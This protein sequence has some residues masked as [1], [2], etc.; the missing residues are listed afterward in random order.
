ML[1]GGE[2]GGLRHRAGAV[3]GSKRSGLDAVGGLGHAGANGAHRGVARQGAVRQRAAGR[4]IALLAD[5]QPVLD[6]SAQ[7]G[8]GHAGLAGHRVHRLN[9][10]A[11]RRLGHCSRVQGGSKSAAVSQAAATLPLPNPTSLSATGQLSRLT[12]EGGGSGR[13]GT[14]AVGTGGGDDQGVGAGGDSIQGV[15]AGGQPG[16]SLGHHA[17]GAQ[18]GVVGGAED[19]VDG[20]GTAGRAQKQ[21]LQ[22]RQDCWRWRPPPLQQQQQ[23]NRGRSACRSSAPLT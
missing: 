21:E 12:S 15:G 13:G 6:P 18:G 23:G 8:G 14:R 10:Q 17:A 9:R 3:V 4:G 16:D 5:L 2:G 20:R 22:H 11:G 7:G 1:G 19:G